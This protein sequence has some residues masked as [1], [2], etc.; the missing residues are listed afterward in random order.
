MF[1]IHSGKMKCGLTE[2]ELAQLGEASEGYSGSDISNV[3]NEAMMLPVR[4]CQTATKFK[5]V[6]DPAA[7]NGCWWEPTNPSDPAGQPMSL[8]QVPPAQLRAPEV[9]VDDY[10]QALANTK[11]SVN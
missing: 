10:M 11:P 2:A 5:Q 7:P 3:V 6:Q 1:K 8:M 4:C 9:T